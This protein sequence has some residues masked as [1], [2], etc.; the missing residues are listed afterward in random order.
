MQNK[1]LYYVN[2]LLS[3]IPIALA[4]LMPVFFLP[5]T[6]EFFEFNKLTLL[7]V[8][9]VLMLVLWCVKI[10]LTKQ[11]IMAKSKIDLPL[12]ALSLVV[13]LSTVFSLNQTTSLFGSAGRWFPSLF[14]F[15]ALVVFYYVG[16]ANLSKKVLKYMVPA[17]LAGTTLSTVL[18]L[19]AY[20]GIYLGKASYLAIQNFSLAGSTTTTAV[21]A[22]MASVIALITIAYTKN[23]LVKTG[24][25]MVALVNMYY[26]PLVNDVSLYLVLLTGL[27]G[28]AVTLPKAKFL[29]NKLH[30]GIAGLGLVLILVVTNVPALK[31]VTVSKTFPGA[32]NL[33]IEDSWRIS[34]STIREFPILGT[35]PSTFYLNFPRYRTLS[36]N[37]T[38][39]WNFRFDKP[40]NELFDI[41]STLGILGIV[42]TLFLI[43][44]VLRLIVDIKDGKEETGVLAVLGVGMLMSLATFAVTYATVLNTFVLFLFLTLAVGYKAAESE[45]QSIDAADTVATLTA[46]PQAKDKS[47]IVKKEYLHF[48]AV[49]PI[50]ALAGVA[51]FF[52][53]RTYAGEYYMRKSIEAS[54]TGNGNQMYDFQ[55]KAINANPRVD[56]YQNAFAQTNLA[57]ANALAGKKD[58]N[59]QDKQNIQTLVAQSIRSSRAATEV[60]NPLN[61]VGWETR[62]SIYAAIAGIAQDAD[63]WA[64]SSYNTAIQLDPT[65]PLLRLQLGG[66]YYSQNDF[67]GAANQFRSAA[68]LKPD[69]ANAHYNFAQALVKLNDPQNAVRALETVKRLVVEGSDDYKNVQKQIDDLKSKIQAAATQQKPTVEQLATN[70]GNVK[71]ATQEPLKNPAQLNQLNTSPQ[72]PV[73]ANP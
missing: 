14:G 60:I 8:A 69:Y 62:A 11:V 6:V 15:L 57:L 40:F 68:T 50:F 64:V 23:L 19:L 32:L 31:M 55:L 51:A 46:Y 25:V 2:T 20:Y 63:K 9:A 54:Q 18:S 29:E 58:L 59:D 5:F 4:F 49:T 24:L 47:G 36:M 35:G 3:Y 16:S 67:L 48:I 42:V 39:F 41:I 53:Y 10:I 43:S 30:Y 65:N 38:L 61:V 21:M 13:I 33:P 28:M 56:T 45:E 26:A 7:A 37:S 17:F 66:V 27:V 34:T 22:L 1:N 71:P 12:I 70:P 52:M 72:Q 73:P 44:R